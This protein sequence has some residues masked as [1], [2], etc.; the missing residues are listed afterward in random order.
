M[1]GTGCC[2]H[3]CKPC[4]TLVECCAQSIEPCMHTWGVSL[5]W[6]DIVSLKDF[7]LVRIQVVGEI[8]GDIIQTHVRTIQIYAHRQKSITM[9]IYA[10]TGGYYCGYVESYNNF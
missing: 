9:S 3:G 4:Y 10:L 1:Q 8:A 6:I 2:V 7:S 5:Q